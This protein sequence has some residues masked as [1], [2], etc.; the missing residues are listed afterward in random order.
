[1]TTTEIVMPFLSE[2][3]TEGTI[4]SWLKGTGD[5][6]AVGEDL[7]VIETDKALVTYD[8]D[9]AGVLLEIRAR[10]GET[11]PTGQVIA[12]IGAPSG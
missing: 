10:P 12:V 9:T 8:S 6:V 7:V 3:M 1:M 11:V 5:A 2:T 4:D